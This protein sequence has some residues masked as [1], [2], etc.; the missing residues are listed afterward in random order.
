MAVGGKLGLFPQAGGTM[1]VTLGKVGMG[2]GRQKGKEEFTNSVSLGRPQRDWSWVRITHL[3][4]GACNE[5]SEA[6]KLP[7]PRKKN[8]FTW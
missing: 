6:Q 2:E 5:A 7:L 1:G 3:Y 8:A 4:L